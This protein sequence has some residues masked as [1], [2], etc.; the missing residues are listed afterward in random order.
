MNTS[1]LTVQCHEFDAQY[2]F[3]GT[4]LSPVYACEKI[5]RSNDG[6][7]RSVLDADQLPF[8]VPGEKVHLTLYYQESGIARLNHESYDLDGVREYRIAWTVE[9]EDGVGECGGNFH[10]R[11]RTPRMEN[12]EGKPIF[13]PETKAGVVGV[14][15]RAQGSNLEFENYPELLR[16]A[17]RRLGIN[18]EYFSEDA[19]AEEHSRVTDGEVYVRIHESVAGRFHAVDGVLARVSNVL[20][21]DRE[22]YRMY[23]ADD[24]KRPGWRH[25]AVVGS[26]RAGELVK[27]HRLAKQVKLYYPEHPDQFDANHPLGHPKLGVKFKHNIHGESVD[28]E[29]LEQMRRELEE[30]LLN[31]LQWEGLPI[32]EED[33]QPV[34]DQSVLGSTA[35]ER[36]DLEGVGPYVA[37]A[38]YRPETYQRQR[39]LVDDPTPQLKEQQESVVLTHVADGLTES[40]WDT[41]EDLVTDGGRLS[42]KEIATRNGWNVETIYAA[43]DRLENIVEHTYGEVSLRS[44]HVAERVTEAVQRARE[45]GEKAVS[46]AANALESADS[47]QVHADALEDWCEEYS[48]TVED[49]GGESFE[50]LLVRVGDLAGESLRMVLTYGLRHWTAAGFAREDFKQASVR[51]ED[52]A[53]KQLGERNAGWILFR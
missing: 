48:V 43:L 37:D 32:L 35:R 1:L 39:R 47:M 46:I 38:Y 44:R 18:N 25:A 33:L 28:F 30:A 34:G 42:P 24:R 3:D 51:V 11:P 41:L 29:R 15:V 40:D 21:S 22:G 4:G 53:S 16:Y 50:D 7:K 10:I 52:P 45:Q 8:D 2:V 5:I 19:L 36:D 27:M 9:D 17:G 23:V 26:K 12:E 31:V 13:T 20:A 14:N 6:A 49:R